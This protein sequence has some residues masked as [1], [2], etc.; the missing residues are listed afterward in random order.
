MGKIRTHNY[1]QKLIANNILGRKNA[2]LLRL[3]KTIILFKMGKEYESSR[4]LSR[5]IKD[6]NV[7]FDI[8]ANIGQYACRFNKWVHP[9]GKVFS[10][11]PVTSNFHYLSL[12]K[13]IL[14]LEN[15][16]IFNLAIGEETKTANIYIPI[17]K[18]ANI[19]VGTRA[20]LVY[21]VDEF[22]NAEMISQ[23]VQLKSIDV[24]TGELKIE[25]L[26]FIKCDTEGA[27]LEVLK[28]GYSTICRDNPIMM[29]EID[30]RDEGLKT[31]YSMGYSPYYVVNNTLV[32]AE[33]VN[34]L[35]T[36]VFLLPKNYIIGD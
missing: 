28:G 20:S 35:K 29:L 16:Q 22:E 21:S 1:F 33:A 27:E 23:E 10:F 6:G 8:G 3:F 31:W 13:T 36:N 15:V 9:R 12:M 32:N 24:L 11:E 4:Y 30:Y 14:N 7:V 26:D 25:K 34:E 5:M 18:Y 19:Q 17:I 2:D